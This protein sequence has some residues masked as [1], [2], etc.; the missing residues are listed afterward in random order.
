MAVLDDDRDRFRRH[1]A[2][3]AGMA[4]YARN[5][6]RNYWH[7][8]ASICRSAGDEAGYAQCMARHDATFT[9]GPSAPVVAIDAARLDPL[10]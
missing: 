7:G 3:L 5:R 1:A 8:Q 4:A 9:P 10:E 2:Q 6:S